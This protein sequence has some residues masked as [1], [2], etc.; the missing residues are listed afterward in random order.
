MEKK[1]LSF[2]YFCKSYCQTKIGT[3]LWTTLYMTT[4]SVM[5]GLSEIFRVNDSFEQKKL[6]CT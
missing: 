5:K 6:T 3:F 2:P 1:S 4:A